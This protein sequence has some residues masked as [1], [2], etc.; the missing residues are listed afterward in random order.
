LYDLRAVPFDEIGRILGQSTDA[1]KMVVGRAREGSGRPS[2][3]R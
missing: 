2:G 3:R 1:T